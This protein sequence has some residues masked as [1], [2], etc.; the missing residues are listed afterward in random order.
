MYRS[1][2]F[3]IQYEREFD[4]ARYCLP[5]TRKTELVKQDANIHT[6]VTYFSWHC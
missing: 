1:S 3:S 4:R 6:K 5:A 2:M